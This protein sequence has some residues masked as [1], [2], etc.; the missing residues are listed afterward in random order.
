[1]SYVKNYRFHTMN[2]TFTPKPNGTY[3]PPAALCEVVIEPL[4]MSDSESICN[5]AEQFIFNG[6]IP[7]L[8]P[9]SKLVR[10]DADREYYVTNTIGF[11][12]A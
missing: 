4:D 5:T 7:P 2:T 6:I 10:C 1:M 11:Y 3:T 12:L 8:P 9:P